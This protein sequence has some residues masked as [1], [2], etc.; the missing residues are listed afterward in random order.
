MLRP[1][2]FSNIFRLILPRRNCRA[3]FRWLLALLLPCLSSL[4]YSQTSPLPFDRLTFADGL[5]D[6]GIRALLQD[7]YGLIWIGTVDGLEMYDGYSFTHY[8]HKPFDATSLTANAITALFE[9]K[10]GTLWIG[11]VAGL[12]RMNAEERAAGRFQQYRHN[13]ADSSSLS[14]DLITAITADGA[15]TIWVG[16]VQGL[17]QLDVA[18]DRFKRY[19]RQPGNPFGLN[20]DNIVALAVD[21]TGTLWVG[22]RMGGLKKF[23]AAAEKFL[24]YTWQPPEFKQKFSRYLP[25]VFAFLDSLQKK[26]LPLAALLRVENSA[27]RKTTFTLDRRSHVLIVATG[28]G[29]IEPLADRGWLNRDNATAPVWQMRLEQTRHA[30]GALKNRVLI[31]TLVLPAGA[32]EL[33]F[34]S[35][36]SHAFAQWNARLPDRPQ[37]WGIQVFRLDAPTADRL[38]AQLRQSF[39]PTA[40]SNPF[41]TRILPDPHQPNTVLWVGTANGL[42]RFETARETFTNYFH[43]PADSQ[44]LRANTIIALGAGESGKILV[45]TAEGGVDQFDQQ[46]LRFSRLAAEKNDAP[47][48]NGHRV[49]A[50]LQ[51]NAGT[52]WAGTEEAGLFKSASK[53]FRRHRL[54]TQNS[55]ASNNILALYESRDGIIWLGTADGLWAYDRAYSRYSHFKPDSKNPKSLRGKFVTS[56]YE[57][58]AGVLW[59]ATWDAGLNRFDRAS[60][61]FTSYQHAPGDSTSLSTN[62]LRAITGDRRG[63]LWI[64][65]AGGG[66]NH[67]NPVTGRVKR[68]GHNPADPHSLPINE[69]NH[70]FVDRAGTLWIGT[71]LGGLAQFEVATQ[72]FTKFTYDP[73]DTTGL[74][75]KTVNHIFEDREGQLWFGTY[76]GGLCKMQRDPAG[77]VTF[78]YYTVE[79]GLPSNMILGLVQDADGIYWISTNHGLSRFEA[80]QP[81]GRQFSNYS[82][83][84][85][86]ELQ[87]LNRNAISISSTAPEE[88]FLGGNNGY[89]SFFPREIIDREYSPPVLLTQFKILDQ[90]TRFAK[91]LADLDRITLTHDQNFFSFEFVA[92]D[93]ANV[94]GIQYA[95]R[96]EGLNE[97]WITCGARRFASFT[98]LDPGEY[99]FRVKATN[100]D[101]V[102]GKHEAAIRISI[103]PPFWRTW[104]FFAASLGAVLLAAYLLHAYR[105]RAAVQTSLQMERIKLFEREQVREQIARD[106][107][108]EMGHKITK[109]GLFSELLKRNVN[110]MAAELEEH[111]DK[112]LEAS[113]NLSLDARDF[114]WALNPE[115]DSL[116]EMCLHLQEFGNALFEETAVN[117]Q[118]HGLSEAL[119]NVKLNMEWK[120]HLTLLFKEG[121][122]NVLK[123]AHCK[124]VALE[125]S[126][127]NGFLRMALLDDGVGLAP[128]NG[129]AKSALASSALKEKRSSGD[130]LENMRRR[131]QVLHGH[132][133]INSPPNGGT[134]IEFSSELPRNGY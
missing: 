12:C 38:R 99:R 27:H 41:V 1:M 101:G 59:I 85:D 108:D 65:T 131:A 111:L 78:A 23:E 80:R 121:M 123:H 79:D 14:S 77:R 73:K 13:A 103:A 112:V 28:E 74:S 9:D 57:D 130:G 5:A 26:Q 31:E 56:L 133:E 6:D 10:G 69:L 96:L 8:K 48:L 83:A 75:N 3:P 84:G 89:T 109:I 102:W 45:G 82:V 60:Q 120:R 63:G 34:L 132:L 134:K 122:N 32:Y 18:A 2:L 104:W 110:G 52:I 70:I 129:Y 117:F 71:V 124:N 94:A 87:L 25:A 47:S 115:K 43:A 16:T 15:G 95:Y 35:D 22:T 92:L 107:H 86:Q 76:S 50:L 116:Y 21:S 49:F 4:T 54:T 119:L 106:Y 19:R 33:N 46:H 98:N 51:D 68:Y 125:I 61:T 30:G 113:Q 67:F 81:R 118:V 91:L 88:I 114:I 100:G 24:T 39:L 66:L 127:Q 58:E 42:N 44:S 29:L 128:A 40:L 97:D 53:N 90:S 72:R 11:T 36:D 37:D 20:D 105:V 126:V 7:R 62:A 55:T 93:Y 64:A 17:N